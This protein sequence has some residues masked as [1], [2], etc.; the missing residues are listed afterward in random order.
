MSGVPFGA[1]SWAMYCVIALD[2]AFH[3][4]HVHLR[5][6]NSYLHALC[7]F[8]VGELNTNLPKS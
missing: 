6:T 2:S 7:E 5:N 1:Y 8:D 3:K 4:V